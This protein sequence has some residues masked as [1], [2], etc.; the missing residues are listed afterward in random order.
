MLCCVQYTSGQTN[1]RVRPVKPTLPTV[2]K[3]TSTGSSTSKSSGT[4]TSKTTTGSSSSSSTSTSKTTTPAP[5]VDGKV[6]KTSKAYPAWSNYERNI[7]FAREA[8]AS[9]SDGLGKFVGYCEKNLADVKLKDPSIDVSAEEKE[10]AE[11]KV[12]ADNMKA[13]TNNAAQEH[14]NQNKWL[15]ENEVNYRKIY[16]SQETLSHTSRSNSN[17]IPVDGKT[18]L[19]ISKSIKRDSILEVIKKYNEYKTVGYVSHGFEYFVK[20]LNDYENYVTYS[21]IIEHAN[22]LCGLSYEFMKTKNSAKA[23]EAAENAQGYCKGVLLQIPNHQKAKDMLAF[24][25]KAYDNATA[26][27]AKAYT[28]NF[29]KTHLNTVVWSTSKLTVGSE[30]EAQISSDFSAGQTIYGTAYFSDK[31]INLM[32]EGNSKLYLTIIMDGQTIHYYDP[33]VVISDEMKQKSYVQFALVPNINDD[34]S[35]DVAK[36]NKTI[37]EFNQTMASKGPLV[38]KISVGMEFGKTDEIIEGSFNYDLSAGT[39]VNEKLFAKI[40]EMFYESARMP[41]A[42]QTNPAIQ[43]AVLNK[44]NAQNNGNSYSNCRITNAAYN[45]DKNEITGIPLRRFLWVT[46]LEKKSD[47]TCVMH[48]YQAVNEYIGSG[49]YSSELKV[50]DNGY[51]QRIK[52]ANGNL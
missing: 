37:M 8:N 9:K 21:G 35:N 45:Y 51:T 5:T 12:T 48:S 34:F 19:E 39:D 23:I 36:G 42:A 52:C 1:P 33:H 43:T 49:N 10:V 40:D 3:G 18:Y 38:Y 20:D 31:L 25:N 7:K 17:P 32:S 16:E 28:S 13:A 41:K 24:A 4:S 30:T 6:P 14:D 47:G 11:L 26:G 50:L 29:H 2:S 44:L 46:V 22:K 15:S 27:M